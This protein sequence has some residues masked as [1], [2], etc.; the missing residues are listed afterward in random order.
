MTQTLADLPRKRCAT[1]KLFYQDDVPDESVFLLFTI[2]PSR[3]VVLTLDILAAK[4][5][6]IATKR[7]DSLHAGQGTSCFLPL[8]AK[9]RYQSL[10][11]KS[12][13]GV[14]L[15]IISWKHN[16]S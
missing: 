7:P 9:S 5:I 10:P 12:S 11:S 2:Y 1:F 8:T 14:S 6:C 15:S 3:S 13:V 4:P 16:R